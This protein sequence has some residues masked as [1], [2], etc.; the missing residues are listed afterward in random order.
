MIYLFFKRNLK[1]AL[2]PGEDKAAGRQLTCL[3]PAVLTGLIGNSHQ[4]VSVPHPHQLAGVASDLRIAF[5]R[6]SRASDRMESMHSHELAL[7]IFDLELKA[8]ELHQEVLELATQS[9]P[10]APRKYRVERQGD[11]QL[12]F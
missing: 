5:E 6:L 11:D 8:V 4:E 7:K 10:A 3:R 12:P 1:T 9:S 2:S